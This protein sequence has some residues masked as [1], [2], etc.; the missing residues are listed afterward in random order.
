MSLFDLNGSDFLL[1]IVFAGSVSALLSVVLKWLLR[2]PGGTLT[3][4]ELEA[5][6]PYAIAYLLGGAQRVV[7]AA[8]VALGRRGLV[9]MDDDKLVRCG[10]APAYEIAAVGVYRGIP[11]EPDKLHPVEQAVLDQLDEPR[12]S[13]TFIAAEVEE[14]CQRLEDELVAHGLFRSVAAHWLYWWLIKLPI[15]VVVALG[16]VKVGVG[17]SRDRP[18]FFLVILLLGLCYM[19]VKIRL[20]SRSTRRADATIA[21][22]MDQNAALKDT[23][24]TAPEQV[25]NGEAALAYALFGSIAIG[26]GLAA[27]SQFL[28]MDEMITG[29][30]MASSGWFSGSSSSSF[31]SCG[32][33][34]GSGCGGGCGSGCGGCGGC[35]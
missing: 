14:P 9:E 15:L 21:S 27:M 5:L 12:S 35:G 33:S 3:S 24:A 1:F 23:A 28:E 13:V 34:C 31:H 32:S 20:E 8:I 4:A 19:A 11:R 16:I 29:A 10:D 2:V 6:D 30:A 26:G 17:V 22:L 18:V 25:T 7:R